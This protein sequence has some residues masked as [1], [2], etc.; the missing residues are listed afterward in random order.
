[1]LQIQYTKKVKFKYTPEFLTITKIKR[2][3]CL[4]A[5]KFEEGLSAVFQ[6]YKHQEVKFNKKL[7]ENSVL[8]V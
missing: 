1:M 2:Y 5:L 7:L 4:I 6:L 8:Y 3:N